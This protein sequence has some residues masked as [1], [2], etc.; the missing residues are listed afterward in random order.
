MLHGQ[1]R[2]QAIAEESFGEY[3]GG[4]SRERAMAVVTVTLLQ[5]IA[6]DFLA[7]GIHLDN[8]A[9]LAPLG[10]QGAAAVGTA[11][12]PGHRLLTRDLGIRDI[13][14]AV[15]LMTGLGAAPTLRAFRWGIGFDG[16]FCRRGGGAKGSL[17]GVP[18]LVT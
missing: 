10:I 1:V 13:A 9:R 16:A 7:H 3:P 8:R 2:E 12:W 14:A 11:P 4:S 6:D 15:S 18:F 17:F 5:F